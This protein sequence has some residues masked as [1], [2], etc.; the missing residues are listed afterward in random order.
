[1]DKPKFTVIKGGGDYTV[2]PA[3]RAFV[4]A[5]ATDT[6][7]MGVSALA[8]LWTVYPYANS[9]DGSYH[10]HQFFYYDAEEYGL[11]S[12]RSMRGDDKLALE[13][14]QRAMIGG[15]GG[16]NVRLTE[17][18]ARYLVQAY[19]R[20]SREQNAELAEP[21]GEYEFIL[22]EPILL[23]D[24]EKG[25]LWRK[26]CCP[27]KSEYHILNYFVMRLTGHD[28][29]AVRYLSDSDETCEKALA[30]IKALS[31]LPVTLYKSELVPHENADGTKTYLAEAV[32]E[33]DDGYFLAVL[34]MALTDDR[35][36]NERKVS[37][38]RVNSSF[39]ISPEEAAM[40]MNRDEYITCYDINVD[41]ETFD[42]MFEIFSLG[43]MLTN[44][45][46]GRLFME[47]NDNNDHVNKPVF[48]LHEDVHGLYYVSDFAQLVI[49]AYSEA[50][51]TEL[52][53][54]I[55]HTPLAEMTAVAGRYKFRETVLY[56]FIDSGAE[57]FV[58]FVE[59]IKGE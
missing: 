9:D 55:A 11:D 58:T 28:R 21:V 52:E 25:F 35:N 16:T 36:M 29:N 38:F 10:F 51:I 22:R 8:I 59:D 27:L 53:F 5:E 43:F 34:E 54:R 19:V 32:L 12:Y 46:N 18:E 13:T 57:D 7:L 2:E 23:S 50:A 20:G 48:K 44:H 14:M 45:D 42:G 3:R 37:L 26:I 6:R 41:P 49:A 15:L 1:M 47:F 56:D 39:R 30:D 40:Q 24:K 33:D 17:R 31:P 4:S